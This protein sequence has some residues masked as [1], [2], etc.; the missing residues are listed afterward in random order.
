MRFLAAVALVM[1]WVPVDGV[2]QD[3]I[4]Q[5]IDADEKMRL[6]LVNEVYQ[7]RDCERVSLSGVRNILTCTYRVGRDLEFVIE[8]IGTRSPVVR[9]HKANREGDFTLTMG[10]SAPNPNS[11]LF[12]RSHCILVATGANHPTYPEFYSVY[13]SQWTGEIYSDMGECRDDG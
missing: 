13:V 3:T 4:H 6:E 5:L 9:V 7:G 2:A 8:N 10:F 11:A 12:G 1:L